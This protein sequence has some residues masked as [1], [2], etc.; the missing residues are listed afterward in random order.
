[1]TSRPT[2]LTKDAGWEVGVSRTLP[3]DPGTM[4]EYLL[5]EPGLSLWLGD[6]VPGPLEKGLPFSTTDGTTGEICSLR[7]GDRVRLTWKPPG[8]QQYAVVQLALRP[9]PTGC[10]VR[11][12]SER[13]DSESE[14][15]TMRFHWR[16]VLDQLAVATSPDNI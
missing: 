12:H 10:S 13:L 6:G 5:S 15:E 2:G 14:R 7:P 8:R 1:M 3:T 11:F 4:W 9:A 16:K